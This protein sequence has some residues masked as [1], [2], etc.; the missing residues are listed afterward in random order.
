MN[1]K[2]TIPDYDEPKSLK[3]AMKRAVKEFLCVHAD[4]VIHDGFV[5]Y[6]KGV[7]EI[8]AFKGKIVRCKKCGREKF[9]FPKKKDNEFLKCI[10]LF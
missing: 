7:R 3:Q 8:V 2:S 1:R 6:Q 10:P 5:E 4:E 9:I